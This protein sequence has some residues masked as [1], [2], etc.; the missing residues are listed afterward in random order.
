MAIT[1]TGDQL[2]QLVAVTAF[3]KEC[4]M[5]TKDYIILN[6]FPANSATIAVTGKHCFSKGSD[7]VT[8]AAL[9]IFSFRYLL[10]FLNRSKKLGIERAHFK[11][12]LCDRA[13]LRKL[14]ERFQVD[15]NLVFHTGR[16]FSFPALAVI[17]ARFAIP[18]SVSSSPAHFTAVIMSLFL[19]R[20]R[21]IL[22]TQVF[23][24]FRFQTDADMMITGVTAK[25]DRLLIV[26]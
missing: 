16:K 26:R 15:L 20:K 24:R 10:S 4:M 13:N 25:L 2:I 5:D 14:R 21:T 12:R 8:W 22:I 7:I 6:S 23:L 9:V 17:E 18:F 19:I 1:A 3:P 11:N